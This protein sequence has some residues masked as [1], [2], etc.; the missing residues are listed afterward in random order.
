MHTYEVRPRKDHRGVDL[1]SD[2]LPFAHLW[3]GE[4]MQAIRIT[5]TARCGMPSQTRLETQSATRC[6]I[7][8]HIQHQQQALGHFEERDQL[9]ITNAA[10]APCRT[11]SS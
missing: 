3:Y 7:A 6:I 11:A 1:I 9:E 8:D 10:H 2:V 5:P 4:L